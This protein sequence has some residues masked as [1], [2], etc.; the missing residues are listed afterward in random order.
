MFG[1][2]LSSVEDFAIVLSCFGYP[3]IDIMVLG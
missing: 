1:V 2:I 3:L